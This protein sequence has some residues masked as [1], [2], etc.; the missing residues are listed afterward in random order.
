MKKII[1]II[2]VLLFIVLLGY[3]FTG[4]PVHETVGIIFIV[5]TVVHNVIHIKW[6]RALKNGAYNRKRKMVTAVNFALAADMA[7]LLL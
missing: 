7:L 5:I 3:S 4:A 6:Y 1:D 2:L